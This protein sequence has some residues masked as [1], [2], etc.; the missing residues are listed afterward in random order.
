[1]Y[2]FKTARGRFL[3]ATSL[4][5]I[6]FAGF[7][8]AET[9]PSLNFYGAPGLI[10]MPSGEAQLDGNLTVSSGHFGPVSRTTLSFQITPRLS[11][12]FRFLGIRDW[13]ANS[14]CQPNCGPS[15]G[16]NQFAT[17]YDRS[18]DVRYQVLRESRYL[19]SVTVGLQ[20]LAG[21]G[22]LSGEYI[23]A[24]KHITP[25]LKGTVGLGWGRLGSH[26]DIGSPFGKRDPINVGEGGDFNIDQWFRGPAAPFA[27][28][29]WQ[30]TDKLTLKAEYSSDD[31]A[32]EAGRR[33]TFEKKSPFNFGAEYRVNPWVTVGGYYMYGSEFGFAA[34]FLMTP[35]Q[36]PTGGIKDG[37]P[38]PVKLRPSRQSDPDAW[39]PEWVT[40]ENA[41][42]IFITNLNKRLE[43]DGIL[44][45]AIGYSAG[46]AQVRIRNTRYNA[47]AQAVGRVARAMSHVMPASVET[48]EI[49]PLVNGMPASKVTLRRSDLERLEFDP[50]ASRKMQ[51][52][53]SVGGPDGRAP[54][55]TYDP[56]LYPS[57][58]WSLAPYNRIR[59][60]DQ[61]EPFKMDVGL[62][63]AARYDFGPG[64]VLQGSATK[65]IAG[66]LDD[67]PPDITTGLQPV[68]S[69]VDLYDANADP[70]LESLTLAK[71]AYLGHDTYGRV[72]VGYLERMF[73]GISTEVL[74]KPSASRWAVGA[75]V[76]YVAQRD[77]D[78][79]FGFSE[80]DYRVATGHLSA[81]Y[82]FAP[83]FHAQL[84]VGRYLAGDVGATLSVDRE[85][86]NGWR[87]GAFATKTDAS[88]E[89]FGSGSFDKGI[90]LEVPLS[91]GIGRPHRKKFET[92][93]RPFGRDGGARLDVSGR[94]YDSIRDYQESGIQEQWGR[95]WK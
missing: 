92:V 28:L 1:M 45:E 66:N 49:V 37:A 18:F 50:D 7:S 15:N 86:E 64:W 5:A 8:L 51:A 38:D 77:T 68:R 70:A 41:A 13:N 12:S 48:F 59:L 84:D 23:A 58:T 16:V 17:Y 81:Y 21:T 20:D 71:Y 89:D 60:F 47:E 34:H 4:A 36:R 14:A 31:Y 83:G 3:L 78:G 53:V 27:G 76:N 85:F 29:E 39:S 46:T 82:A 55:L 26:G 6:G 42:P 35:G 57:F 44:V 25:R 11:A 94:L 67:P 79:Q 61:R 43:Q 69:D 95:F 52:G 19:P 2:R 87:V 73:G 33:G 90:R 74:Y 62:R 65:K 9:G 22:I 24:T 72:T 80:Y 10:D 93:I 75:E 56:A 40:Q 32:L 88:A 91:W 63:L 30:A 54:N